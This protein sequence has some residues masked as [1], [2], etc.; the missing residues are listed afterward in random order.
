MKADR[1]LEVEGSGW[2]V[3]QFLNLTDD[4]T[5]HPR[6][7]SYLPRSCALITDGTKS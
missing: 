6:R 2:T 5:E 3:F 7:R 4:K 1:K